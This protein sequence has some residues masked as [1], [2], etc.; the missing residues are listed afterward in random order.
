MALG[1][2]CPAAAQEARELVDPYLRARNDHAVGEVAGQAF[3]D[4]PRASAPPV[5][6]EG[7]SMLLL[8]Y[9]Q[10][11][12]AE[13]D[14]IKDHFRDS[15]RNYMEATAD[16][17]AA[18]MAYE[19]ALLAAGGGELI[20][21]EVSDGRGVARLAQ[22][23]AGQWLLLAWREQVHPGKAPKLGPRDLTVFRDIPVGAGYSVVTY[24]RMRLLVRAGETIPVELNDR[25]VWIT[26]IHEEQHL[27][28]GTAKKAGAK[29]GR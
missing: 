1:P 2:A 20:R 12:E 3:G 24:W 22:V 7:V 5:P 26:G 15:L 16:V 18:R 14:G 8:P 10:A 19:R 4:A 28:E 11:L 21:G 6:Y 25:N 27:I 23:P 9:S 29:K 17:R 13:L